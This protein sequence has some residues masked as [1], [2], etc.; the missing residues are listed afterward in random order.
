MEVNNRAGAGDWDRNLKLDIRA[1]RPADR[2]IGWNSMSTVMRSQRT[3]MHQRR[4]DAADKTLDIPRASREAQYGLH[5]G[6]RSA[7]GSTL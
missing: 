7:P 6:S 3:D 2:L 4:A 5:D 1:K